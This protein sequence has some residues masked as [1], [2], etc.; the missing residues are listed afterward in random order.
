MAALAANLLS[1]GE[2]EVGRWLANVLFRPQADTPEGAP[3]AALDDFW[4]VDGLPKIVDALGTDGLSVLLPW[5]IEYERVHGNLTDTYDMTAWTRESVRAANPDHISGHRGVEQALIDAVRDL[6]AVAVARRPQEVTAAL[7]SS[8]MALGRKL[9]LFAVAKALEAPE[10]N[11]EEVDALLATA[12]GLMWDADTRND[13]CRIEFGELARAV[14]NRSP[15][16]LEPL[17]GFLAAGPRVELDELRERLNRD[18]EAEPETLDDRVADY[19]DRW[20]HRWLAAVGRQALRPGLREALDELDSRF[21]VIDNP[22]APTSKITTWV[23]PTSPMS[24]D[25]MS[26]MSP[27]ELVAH[28]ESWHDGGDRFGPAPSHEGQGRELT[29]LL[30]T[31]PLALSGEGALLGRLRPT[32]VSAALRGWDGA[33]R[34]GLNLN[35]GEV[36]AVI[37][38]VLNHS[39]ESEF[40]VEGRRDWDD[41]ADYRHAKHVAVD[42]LES[43]VGAKVKP[44][45][46]EPYLTA[47]ADLLIGPANDEAAWEEYIE[48]SKESGMDPLNLSINWRWPVRTRGLL[49]LLSHG[50]GAPWYERAREALERE[51]QRDDP[52]AASAAAVGESL[53]RLLNVDPEWIDPRIPAIFGETEL[54]RSQQVALTTAMAVH[55][56]HPELYKVLSQSMLAAIA[57]GD[58]LEPGWSSSTSGPLERIGDWVIEGVIRGD[59]SID[60][61]VAASFFVNTSPDVRGRALGHVAWRFFHADSVDPEIRDRFAELWDTRF[62]HVRRSPADAQELSKFYWAVKCGKFPP[63]WWLPRLKEAVELEPHLARERY[64]IGKDLA[65][66]SESDPAGALDALRALI[67]ARSDAT[68][69]ALELTRNAVPLIIAR[70]MAAGDERLKSEATAFMNALG[71]QGYVALEAEVHAVLEGRI[72]QTEVSDA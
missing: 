63:A 21:G 3:A 72:G 51:L 45:V 33:L 42:L 23:G 53:G 56:Y 55:Y 22:L 52:P 46:P 32:Y 69:P 11:T 61:P 50:K 29:G 12:G 36:A 7:C 10:L 41:E 48:G 49:K 65:M 62:Q 25:E 28:L 38:D 16:A 20:K 26:V 39:D 66:A 17:E 60:D 14:A 19:V 9:A 24:Q 64:M 30:T 34:A 4:Y 40:P 57:L 27:N 6:A 58:A 13:A 15:E 43:L 54:T 1:G 8:G 68:M 71:E 70:A 31:N 67:A 2:V 18:P 44:E 35:W 5:L 59:F 47:Y 37:R